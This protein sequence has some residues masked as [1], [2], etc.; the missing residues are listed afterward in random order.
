MST[1]RLTLNVDSRLSV[2]AILV[3]PTRSRFC[4]VFA[5]GAG[6]GMTH[7]F[8][9]TAA[10][11]LA[12]RSI[13]TLRFNFPYM[14]QGSGRPDRPAICHATVRAAVEAAASRLPDVPLV[15]GGKSFGGRMTSQAQAEGLLP[16]VRGLVFFGFPLHAAGKPDVSRAQHLFK[17]SVPLLFLQGARDRLADLDRLKNL[18]VSLGP[19]ATLFLVEEADHSFHVPARTGRD[20]RQVLISII[21]AFDSWLQRL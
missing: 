21:D 2:S 9:E 18:A 8:M 11:E 1:S 13:A 10:A 12:T 16:W 7:A 14:E 6:A 20:D 3:E 17:V 5:H 19:K 15:A 4:Y